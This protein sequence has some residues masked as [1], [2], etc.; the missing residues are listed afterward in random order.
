MGG[1]NF[2][3]LSINHVTQI[4]FCPSCD[5]SFDSHNGALNHCGHAQTHLGEW[6][7]RCERLFVSPAARHAHITSSPHHHLCSLCDLD[8]RTAK[9]LE[10]HEFDVHNMCGDCGKFFD[11]ANQLQQ[12]ERTHL[13]ACIGCLGC[14]RNFSEFAA[15]MIHLESGACAS[16]T[17][18]GAIN[19]WVFNSYLCHRYTNQYWDGY[20]YHCP[21]C[22]A[23]FRFV[24]AL[25]QHVATDACDQ[26]PDQVFNAIEDAIA[27]NL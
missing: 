2:N 5:R 19:T 22:G 15:M 1:A 18:L 13:P 26:D 9:D 8:Y 7:E 16:N 17:D 21:G 4:Y 20:D 14:G 24:S 6:C 3:Q 25:C 12:H 10:D 27:Y 11:D 23:D